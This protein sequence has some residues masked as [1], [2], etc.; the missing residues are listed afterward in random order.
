MKNITKS[1]LA[2][3]LTCS[4]ANQ[5]AMTIINAQEE[6]SSDTKSQP[7]ISQ[8]SNDDSIFQVDPELN[9]NYSMGGI[10]S[11]ATVN[12]QVIELT[13]PK[14]IGNGNVTASSLNVRSG[15]S[16]STTSLGTVKNGD[17]LDIL[18][19]ENNW[20]KIQFNK[21]TGYV[22]ASYMDLNPIQKGIDVSKWNGDINWNKVKSSGIDYV[23]IRAGYGTST[24]DPYFTKNIKGAID[25]GLEVGVYWFS[26]ATTPDK[27]KI[28]AQNCLR[29]LAPYKNSITYPVFYDYEYDSVDYAGKNGITITK[30]LA[31]EMANVFIKEVESQGYDSGIYTNQDFG[32]RYFSND[33]LLS[34]NLWLAQYRTT[35][36]YNR[37]YMMWQ[38]TDKGVVNGISGNVDMNYTYLRTRP[39]APNLIDLSNATI[40]KI[41][42]QVYTG[43]PITPKVNLS[44]DNNSLIEGTDFEVIYENNKSVG[45]STV[46]INGIGNYEGSITTT[47]DILPTKV[48]NLKITDKTIS[49]L[50]LEWEKVEDITGYEIYRSDSNTDT[51]KLI[52]TIDDSSTLTYTDSNLASDMEYSYKIKAFKKSSSNTFYGSYSDAVTDSTIKEKVYGTTTANLNMRSSASTSSSIIATIPKGTKVEIIDKT[53]STWYKVSY[54][55]KLGYVS[56][57]YLNLN[58][59]DNSSDNNDSNQPSTNTT[60]GVVTANLNMRSST[61]TSSSIIATIPKGTK[62]E[63]VEKTSSTWYKVRY[64]GK[65]GYVSSQYLN[66]NGNDNSNDN[67][68]SNQPSTN[69]TYGVTTANLNMRSS[70]STSSSIIATIPKGTKIEIIEKTSSTWY[71]VKYNNKTGYVSSQYVTLN[72]DSSQPPTNITYGVTTTNL[73]M[74]SSASTS[75]S[76]IATIPKGTKIEILEKNSNGWYK[77]KYNNK[78][79]YASSDYIN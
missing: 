50:K 79:G 10:S 18:G 45:T 19:K 24:I 26:Y 34:N 12:S 65:L 13:N 29:A 28:E 48:N 1:L 20:Y 2:F 62:I 30:S 9:S 22:S 3:S 11:R 74:R 47:F 70:T 58:G 56:S 49:T 14:A 35:A 76:I 69:T 77:V 4:L 23:I 78:T 40:N 68:N 41:E 72:N 52:K 7:S 37:P 27:A 51:Y 8:E 63:I 53:S 64:N 43:N 57:Q 75:S 60:Y 55:G 67:N 25:A 36:S 33:I 42:S 54:N 5:N 71:K 39:S 15:P 59:N 21:E 32:D 31:T 61:S 17:N 44:Y 6:N 16:S 73:N 46:T 38:Y 66:L